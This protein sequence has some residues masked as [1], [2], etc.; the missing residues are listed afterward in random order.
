MKP[1]PAV[2]FDLRPS[3]WVGAAALA[4]IALAAAA[5][6]LSSLPAPVDAAA[7]LAVLALG[8]WA[9][10]R[11]AHPRFRRAAWRES[12]WTLVDRERREHAAVLESHARLGALLALDFRHEPR[13]R[14]RFVLAP[15]NL[16]AD[17]RR[18]LILVL[19][20]GDDPS[21]RLPSIR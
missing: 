21:R 14:F 10:W 15:D 2:A 20:R 4:V 3:R 7:S 11:H 17:A 12:G 16:D 8:A 9:L 18:R 6:W 13:A 1:A 19:A 5:P